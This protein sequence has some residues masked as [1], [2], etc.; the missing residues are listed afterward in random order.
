MPLDHV[1]SSEF[2]HVGVKVGTD[3]GVEMVG[4]D[5]GVEVV[6]PGVAAIRIA[7]CCSQVAKNQKKKK[8]VTQ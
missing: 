3:V 2:A 5:V 8:R 1:T 6:G 4:A 7:T